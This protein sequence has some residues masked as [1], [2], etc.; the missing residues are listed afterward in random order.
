MSLIRKVRGFFFS[1]LILA[2]SGLVGAEAQLPNVRLTLM[3]DVP[4]EKVFGHYVLYGGFGAHGGFIQ[5]PSSRTIQI[6][7]VIDG[8]PA[9]RIKM[10]IGAPGC[11][12]ATFDIPIQEFSDTQESF[13]C[14]PVSTV[15]FEGQISPARLLGNKNA[16]VSFDYMAGWA[17]GFFGLA[18]CMV[19]QISLGTA[20]PDAEGIFKIELTDFS[21]DSSSSDSNDGTELQ[22]ILRDAETYNIL[23][24]LEP[25]SE[26]LRT[27]SGNLRISSLYPENV[28]FLARKKR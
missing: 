25:E 24:F 12:I 17:C 4:Y 10:F 18:D 5:K 13:S 22:F 2:L 9:R 20:K 1:S 26:T 8:K 19:P 21:A 16:E 27:A 14:T 15:T 7:A 3:P 28:V 11:K 6:P 23:T